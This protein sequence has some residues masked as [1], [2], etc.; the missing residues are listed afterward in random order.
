MLGSFW[1]WRS[2]GVWTRV[3]LLRKA[4]QGGMGQD[5]SY[6]QALT[7]RPVSTQMQV[8]GP[9]GAMTLILARKEF[10]RLPRL[11]GVESRF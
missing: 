1:N 6:H 5:E 4:L 2:G 10:P 11:T 3:G 8:Q 7:E 9:E